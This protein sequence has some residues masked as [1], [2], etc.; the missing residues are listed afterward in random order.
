MKIIAWVGNNSSGIAFAREVAKAT[1]IDAVPMLYSQLEPILSE[2]DTLII[3][4][5]EGFLYDSIK[6]NLPILTTIPKLV[7][8]ICTSQTE[9]TE[10]SSE[11]SFYVYEVDTFNED[12][13]VN[14]VS[15]H[16]KEFK[17]KNK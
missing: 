4:D 6:S 14:A 17:I 1:N 11:K 9:E 5:S 10:L 12:S 16:Q 3:L 7:I 2:I 15:T 8:Y 13:V